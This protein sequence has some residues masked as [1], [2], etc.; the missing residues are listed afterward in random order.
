MFGP[1]WPLLTTAI[2]VCFTAFVGRFVRQG[3]IHR[4]RVRTLKAQGLPILPHSPILGHLLVLAEF[5]KLH[6][7]DVNIHVFHTW[8]SE[9]CQK[10]FPEHEQLPPVVYLDLWPMADSLA[11]VS[12]PEMISQFTVV[13]N[14]PK[15]SMVKHYIR[16]L[17]SAIDI[18]CIEGQAWK[19]W[20][21]VLNPGFS[22]RNLTTMVP[23]II[24]EV[25]VFVDEL[26]K[27]T[28]KNGTWGSVF[29]LEQKTINLT[30]DVICRATLDM[31]LHEQTS[32]SASPL[33]AALLDQLR[34]MAIMTNA[35]K[36]TLLGRMP[37]HT[38]AIANNNRIMKKAL[39][40]QIEA[41]LKSNSGVTNKK[42]IIDLAAQS[43][44]ESELGATIPRPAFLESL[45]ANLKMFLFAG[46]DTTSST[47]CFMY[48][49][50]QDNPQ[51]LATLREEHDNILGTDL[52]NVAEVISESPHLL[53]SLPYTLGVIKETLRLYTQAATIRHC[54]PN[55]CLTD[56]STNT[57]YPMEGFEAW[58]STPEI[59]CSAQYWLRPEEFLPERWIAAEGDPLRPSH[60]NTW[61]P[62]SI[63][64]RNCIGMELAMIELKLVL[65]LTARVFDVEEAWDEWDQ[66]RGPK[67]TPSHAIKGQRLYQVGISTV[68][69]KDGMPVHVRQRKNKPV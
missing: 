59:H 6:P 24:E 8:L 38:A 5:T 67:A 57:R 53:S 55:F 9:N 20:R 4:S 30:F 21:S 1:S 61:V 60:S 3:Y 41:R 36:A 44:Q 2:A 31:R 18:F 56:A 26:K 32:K 49:L 54:P 10:Y 39:L 50:L 27:V 47:I 69:P 19:T 65:A 43:F 16:P 40:P 64:P 15:T 17:T 25:L 42:T 29:Q 7:P 12:N 23:E 13:Q 66:Q 34:L 51:A 28:G 45:T 63:G 62:F 68:H 35:A 14:L 22:T 11:I 52:E 37:W 33:K 58:L 46:H 48:K